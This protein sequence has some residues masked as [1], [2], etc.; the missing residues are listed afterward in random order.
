[1]SR[2]LYVNAAIHS[3]SVKKK[4]KNNRS[5]KDYPY[6]LNIRMCVC[7]AYRALMNFI[8]RERKKRRGMRARDRQARDRET[9]RSRR[10]AGIDGFTSNGYSLTDVKETC[11]HTRASAVWKRLLSSSCH[12]LVASFFTHCPS[13]SSSLCPHVLFLV[14]PCTSIYSHSDSSVGAVHAQVRWTTLS[15]LK[16]CELRA[17]CVSPIA[18]ARVAF[19]SLLLFLSRE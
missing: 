16:L 19:F 8:D 7:T 4:K 13:L 10:R 17:A 6:Q 2:N 11:T 9:G 3:I 5:G 14:P 15:G 18:R 12:S 1:M